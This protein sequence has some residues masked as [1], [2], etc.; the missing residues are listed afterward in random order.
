MARKAIW[1]FVHQSN[2]NMRTT[3]LL[4]LLLLMNV[5]AA[6]GQLSDKALDGKVTSIQTLVDE[7]AEAGT[8]SGI[9]A[10]GTM[11][12]V[13]WQRTYGWEDA[14]AQ[15]PNALSTRFNMGSIT[16]MM[17]AVAIGQL[18]DAGSVRLDATVGTYVPDYP[19]AIVRDSVTVAQLLNH[20]SGLQGYPFEHGSRTVRG[21][22]DTFS[23]EPL[24]FSPGSG[25]AYSNAG[26]VVA[27]L[28]IERV[29]GMS[30]YEYMARRV[31]EP[32]GMETA[33]FFEST[34]SMRDRAVPY[35]LDDATGERVPAGHLL[36][37]IGSPAGGAYATVN[38]MLAFGR[39]L[40]DGTLLSDETRNVLFQ[41]LRPMGP[42][43]SYGY[44]VGV[45]ET[46]GH[47][48]YGHNG[49]G[50]GM[51][52]D[53]RIYP[54]LGATTVLFNNFGG[55]ESLRLFRNVESVLVQ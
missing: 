20:T 24:A 30:Y 14:G 41:P 47:L 40:L 52:A 9:A 6:C 15:R 43:V 54:D 48:S 39:A 10:V 4:C 11:N 35:M 32:A 18:I 23:Q 12:G 34:G 51:T 1:W 53:F 29:T 13:Y 5:P 2:V 16:K 26:F 42:G 49:G 25:D 46:N 17:T 45:H 19:Q 7:Q 27:G 37:L 33:G 31:F 21:I 36:E 22:V 55:R 38:D 8:F 28:I 3:A 50:P 44:G